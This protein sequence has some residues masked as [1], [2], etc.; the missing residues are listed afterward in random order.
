MYPFSNFQP[1]E[2]KILIL[3]EI[4]LQKSINVFLNDLFSQT[5]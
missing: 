5:L 4:V 1:I 3:E 2:Q